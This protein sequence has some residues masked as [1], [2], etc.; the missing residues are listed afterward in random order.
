M[1]KVIRDMAI[2]RAEK[3]MDGNGCILD[4]ET[5][6]L[7]S[8]SQ[9][10][11]LSVIDMNGKTL[12]NEKFCPTCE[13]SES[14]S[15]VNGFSKESLAFEPR[16]DEVWKEI[17]PVLAEHQPVVAYNSDFDKRMVK[18]TCE[19]F[20]LEEPSLKWECAMHLVADY[21]QSSSGRPK[22]REDRNDI[23]SKYPICKL[24]D[25]VREMSLPIVDAHDALGDVK[26]T[27]A[28]LKAMTGN[29][30]EAEKLLSVDKGM[31]R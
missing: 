30:S 13:I 12:I 26:M 19:A 2:E 21:R 22:S 11:Q 28:V 20:G 7:S 14:A 18:Q 9:I 15:R 10:V 27:L 3:L 8:D 23:A 5:T 17:L 6:G 24:T 31:Q 1:Q 25:F 16:F 4:T 29:Q